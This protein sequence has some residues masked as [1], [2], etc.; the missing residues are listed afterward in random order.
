MT[1]V[2]IIPDHP[3]AH[4]EVMA[5]WARGESCVV[6]PYGFEDPSDYV[7]AHRGE[8]GIFLY[9]AN[10]RGGYDLTHVTWAQLQKRLDGEITRPLLSGRVLSMLE[11]RWGYGLVLGRLG[12]LYRGGTVVPYRGSPRRAVRD[13]AAERVEA[14]VG[15]ADL[16]ADAVAGEPRGE[17]ALRAIVNVC[18]PLPAEKAAALRDHYPGVGIYHLF[19]LG[20]CGLIAMA[21][22]RDLEPGEQGDLLVPAEIRDGELFVRSSSTYPPYDLGDGWCATGKRGRIDGVR[23]FIDGD[24]GA[25]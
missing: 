8:A 9:M 13:I 11:N 15:I 4:T 19:G 20:R 24:V 12:T 2:R 14:V 5:A 21:T 23:L 25:R 17:G 7:A 10:D 18:K 3:L 6:V 16:L 1:E 22:D